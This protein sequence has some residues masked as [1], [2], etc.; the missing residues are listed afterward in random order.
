MRNAILSVKNSNSSSF[1]RVVEDSKLLRYLEHPWQDHLE[2][3]SPDKPCLFH[4]SSEKKSLGTS[5]RPTPLQFSNRSLYFLALKKT[6]NDYIN[7]ET[8]L[9]SNKF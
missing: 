4:F 9:V 3:V 5:N 1:L 8:H 7:F 6:T 2:L